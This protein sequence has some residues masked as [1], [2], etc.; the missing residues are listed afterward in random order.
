LQTSSAFQSITVAPNRS[1]AVY[2]GPASP[3]STAFRVGSI[4]KASAADEAILRIDS[5][6]AREYRAY[7]GLFIGKSW[8]W[9]PVG[10][11][12][13]GTGDA[14]Y[15]HV[16]AVLPMGLFRVATTTRTA[17]LAVIVDNPAAS[18][19]L[20]P[21]AGAASSPW[22]SE[23]ISNRWDKIV[24]GVP[25]GTYSVSFSA[26]AGVQ[27]PPTQNVTI[28]NNGIVSVFGLFEAEGH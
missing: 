17:T 12:E 19:T 24:I 18:F 25:P 8:E 7:N 21:P 15:L 3:D 22:I 23:P 5:M 27:A 28:P 1:F 9:F 11:P 14:I 4:S 10:L 26:P 2:A 13:A 6:P 16:P 20:T